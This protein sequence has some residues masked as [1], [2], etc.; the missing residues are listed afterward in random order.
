MILK[1]LIK[2]IKNK[3]SRKMRININ[4]ALYI[5][6]NYIINQLRLHKKKSEIITN[7]SKLLTSNQVMIGVPESLRKVNFNIN[8]ESKQKLD[9]T[10]TEPISTTGYILAADLENTK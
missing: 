7:V 6:L 8:T 2:T 9:I 5:Y 10:V 1:N 4:E 3:L